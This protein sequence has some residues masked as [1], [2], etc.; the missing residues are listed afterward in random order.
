MVASDGKN[1]TRTPSFTSLRDQLQQ[2]TD[3]RLVVIDPLQAFVTA[4]VNGDP[5]AAQFMWTAMAELASTTGA[6]IIV[7]HHM[8]KEGGFNIRNG[9]DAREAIRG[10]TALVDGA[11]FA[12]ALWK[13]DKEEAASIGENLSIEANI[14]NVARGALVKSNE[15]ADFSIHTYIRNESGLLE[16]CANEVNAALQAVEMS[17][18][19][20]KAREILEEIQQRFE[21]GTPFSHAP[22]SGPRYLISF[23]TRQHSMTRS[24]AQNLL[25]DWMNNNVVSV[26]ICDR[27]TKLTGLKVIKWL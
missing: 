11:R 17:F 2:I 23:L 14:N 12:Y 6:T 1:L 5:A 9:D 27:K 24:R 20:I 8:R 7:T 10:T 26:D 13:V 25:A 16:Q 4:D 22:N 15:A 21:H 19:L 3:L 18:T